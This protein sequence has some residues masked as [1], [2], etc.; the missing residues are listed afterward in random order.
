MA[1]YSGPCRCGRQRDLRRLRRRTTA[2]S[3]RARRKPTS[4]THQY[5]FSAF[6][7]E[8]GYLA[9]SPVRTDLNATIPIAHERVPHPGRT[10]AV[11]VVTPRGQDANGHV[12]DATHEGHLVLELELLAR[13]AGLV[14]DPDDGEPG[15][16]G[17]Q[18]SSL[19]CSSG[20]DSD[21][22]VPILVK[23]AQFGDD[24]R[25]EP[26][27]VGLVLWELAAVSRDDQRAVNVWHR[28]CFER[29]AYR[30]DFYNRAVPHRTRQ[31]WCS[32]AGRPRQ[33]DLRLRTCST[34]GGGRRASALCSARA[35]E[36]WKRSQASSWQLQLL[37][38]RGSLV[39][40]RGWWC[41]SRRRS[42]RC[43]P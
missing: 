24:L 25:F 14:R 13:V 21:P 11:L 3:L 6:R 35:G 39:L 18:F 38:L 29:S 5:A 28:R 15:G 42:S 27:P 20:V 43:R 30:L 1:T 17:H 22:H 33:S 8:T 34:C 10:F 12:E 41:W 16:G 7:A 26:G 40:E 23:L 31:S 4:P 37:L 19:S 2:G 36:R 32:V 9:G